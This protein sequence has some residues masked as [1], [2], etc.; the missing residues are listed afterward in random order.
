M[1]NKRL[2]IVSVCLLWLAPGLLC[3]E[4]PQYDVS[5]DVTVVTSDRL[6]F[7]YK[8]QYALFEGNVLVSDPEMDL[9]AQS[10]IIKFSEESEVQSIVAKTGVIIEQADK[11]AEAGVAVYDVISGKV[12]LEDN[13][14][15]RRGKDILTG[16]TI[17]F[18][19]DENKMVCEPRARL[20]IFPEEGGARAKLIGD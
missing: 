1:R 14:R 17:T 18:W 19:R 13:P 6:V 12:V 20:I 11:R 16:D 9:K 4:T 8:K 15:V 10:L 2:A 3:A 7:D 5:G